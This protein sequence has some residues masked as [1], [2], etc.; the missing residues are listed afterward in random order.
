MI[1]MSAYTKLRVRK[2]KLKDTLNHRAKFKKEAAY[3]FHGLT[4]FYT[5]TCILRF[6]AFIKILNYTF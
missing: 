6:Q 2:E 1:K 3:I 5:M 4:G